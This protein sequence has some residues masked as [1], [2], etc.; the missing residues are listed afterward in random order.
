MATIEQLTAE[1]NALK[2]RVDNITT[3][4]HAEVVNKMSKITDS[5]Q[6]YIDEQRIAAVGTADYVA[7]AGS[8]QP[9]P[10]WYPFTD[11]A[12]IT[13]WKPS[14]ERM[15]FDSSRTKTKFVQLNLTA[16]FLG[17]STTYQLASKDNGY[18]YAMRAGTTPDANVNITIPNGLSEGF[19]TILLHPGA[20]RIIMTAGEGAIVNFRNS[21]NQTTGKGAPATILC[22]SR[23]SGGTSTYFVFGDLRIP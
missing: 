21:M 3:P 13:H 2:A 4:T 1:L 15:M 6:T 17:S 7:P 9:A 22:T 19:T 11:P 23:T 8:G 5:L 18:V 12:G 20:G 16:G 10:G 14:V